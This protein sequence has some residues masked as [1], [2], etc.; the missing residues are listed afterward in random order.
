M[1]G[2]AGEGWQQLFCNADMV[3]ASKRRRFHLLRRRGEPL[4]LIPA[5]PKLLQESLSLYPAQTWRARLVRTLVRVAVWLRLPVLTEPFSLVVDEHAA[6]VKFTASGTEPL[7]FAMLFGNPKAAGRRFVMLVFNRFGHPIKVIK[8][9]MGAAATALIRREADFLIR[10]GNKPKE[11]PKLLGSFDK[12]DVSAI[13]MEYIPGMTPAATAT[14]VA[15]R[16]LGT[17]LDRESMVAVT[18]LPAWQRLREVAGAEPLFH[19]LE[20]SVAGLRLRPAIFHGDFAPWN[21][22]VKPENGEWMVLD[23][24][25]GESVGPPA[26]D[27]FHFVIQPLLLVAKFPAARIAEALERHL[28]SSEFSAYAAAAH[29]KP[30]TRPLFLGYLLYCQKVL[31][32]VEGRETTAALLELLQQRWFPL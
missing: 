10:P 9:G 26:W 2:T 14:G 6:F 19:E 11:I 32:P 18:E 31:Q 17:W 30:I 23:W 3:A 21:I 4:L 15:A 5:A 28:D 8:V 24:E 25:R 12:A 29:I 20:A 13:A 1:S 22:R 27:W 16:V 7:L